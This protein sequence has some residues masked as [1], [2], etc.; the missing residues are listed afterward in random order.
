MP[1]IHVYILL[2]FMSLEWVRLLCVVYFLLWPCLGL[3][4]KLFCRSVNEKRDRVTVTLLFL[5][6]SLFL[7]SSYYYVILFVFIVVCR[8]GAVRVIFWFWARSCFVL[9]SWADYVITVRWT[10]WGRILFV[11]INLCKKIIKVYACTTRGMKSDKK[12]YCMLGRPFLLACKKLW[13]DRSILEDFRIGLVKKYLDTYL[14]V[15]RTV[16]LENRIHIARSSIDQTY[17]NLEV[18]KTLTNER[19]RYIGI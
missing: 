8:S 12:R 1:L 15:L 2:I 7:F 16:N 13:F 10:A 3:K 19:S 17:Q 4:R 18:V 14:V 11:A 6:L 5:F 9:F